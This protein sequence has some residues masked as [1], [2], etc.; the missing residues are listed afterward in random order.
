M[1]ETERSSQGSRPGRHPAGGGEAL[2]AHWVEPMSEPIDDVEDPSAITVARVLADA[3]P[4]TEAELRERL[5]ADGLLERGDEA[6]AHVALWGA[7]R[8]L[9]LRDGRLVHLA[10][11]AGGLDD[12]TRR[13]RVLALIDEMAGF[14]APGGMS[15]A[16]VRALLGLD[17]A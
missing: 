1:G 15:A 2:D 16:R 8:I 6:G 14:E 11:T 13:D 5:A 10:S 3:R 4:L 9:T 7:P 17:G 12:P